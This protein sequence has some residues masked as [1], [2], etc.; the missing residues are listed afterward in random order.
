ML[1]KA[2]LLVLMGLDDSLM[3]G[4]LHQRYQI[5]SFQDE[6]EGFVY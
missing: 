4:P 3:L 2:L 6:P 1:Y 5:A